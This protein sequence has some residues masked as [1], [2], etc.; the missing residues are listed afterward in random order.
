MYN[1]DYLWFQNIYLQNDLQGHIIT[2]KLH[3]VT[4]QSS[5]MWSSK[6]RE[7]WSQLSLD[8]RVVL[9]GKDWIVVA[10]YLL[11]TPSWELNHEISMCPSFFNY[12]I[13]TVIWVSNSEELFRER[14]KNLSDF[15]K[16]RL[17]LKG[18]IIFGNCSW[19]A[20]YVRQLSLKLQWDFYIILLYN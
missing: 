19:P 15:S 12:K 2:V 5:C 3:S 18:V 6:Q 16:N 20:N 9:V 10:V 4:F 13:N 8:L 14:L 17:V 1:N 11:L 7:E